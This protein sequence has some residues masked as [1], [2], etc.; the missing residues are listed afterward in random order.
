MDDVT[1]LTDSRRIAVAGFTFLLL[2]ALFSDSITSISRDLSILIQSIGDAS[3]S[4][5]LGHASMF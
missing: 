5:L 4:A 1:G 3:S 2:F